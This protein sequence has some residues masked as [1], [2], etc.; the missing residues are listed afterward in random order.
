MSIHSRFVHATI[1]A[2]GMAEIELI[3]AQMRAEFV[4][5]LPTRIAKLRAA[6]ARTDAGDSEADAE[7]HTLA[8]QLHGTG[9][10]FGFAEITAAAAACRSSEGAQLRTRV[11]AL[12]ELLV[13]AHRDHRGGGA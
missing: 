11:D 3:R 13:T 12:I 2:M 9:T 6:K 4:A 10:T 1:A 5:G 7:L 8:H